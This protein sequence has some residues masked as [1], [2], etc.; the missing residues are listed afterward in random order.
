VL[1]IEFL[2]LLV[3]LLSLLLTIRA[4]G[5]RMVT[6][7]PSVSTTRSGQTYFRDSLHIHNKDVTKSREPLCA[8]FLSRKDADAGR[9]LNTA[10][11]Y[12]HTISC[13]GV[14]G[15]GFAQNS[16]Q[17]AHACMKKGMTEP[18]AGL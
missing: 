3:N 14:S 17:M 16:P 18:V 4:K 1:L 11:H 5:Y 13:C 10:V 8:V 2:C 7:A 6:N 15:G 12:L 9:I